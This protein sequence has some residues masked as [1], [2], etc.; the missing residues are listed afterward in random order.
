[1]EEG[2]AACGPVRRE[3]LGA[4]R[5]H[6]A[7][8]DI[9]R[10]RRRQNGIAGGIDRDRSIAGADQAVPPL[11]ERRSSR[12]QATDGGKPVGALKDAA[13]MQA[14]AE[15]LVVA[16]LSDDDVRKIFARNA[17]RVLYWGMD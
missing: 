5:R 3:P 12:G 8:Q 13:Q 15:A 10:A 4:Q 6:H 14:L 1:M 2:C 16:G 17:L 11:Q 7:G 9:A